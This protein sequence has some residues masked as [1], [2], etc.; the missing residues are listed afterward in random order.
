MKKMKWIALPV[1]VGLAFILATVTPSMLVSVE[2]LSED[3]ISPT[4][5][6][7]GYYLIPYYLHLEGETQGV[8]E[9]SCFFGVNEGGNWSN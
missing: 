5:V 7:E 8:I 1:I 3:V 4:V 6:G 2:S 9:G